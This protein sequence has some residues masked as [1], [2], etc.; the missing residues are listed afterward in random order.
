MTSPPPCPTGRQDPEAGGG[1]LVVISGPSGVGKTTICNALLTQHLFQ[2]VVTATSRPPR[3]GERD[4][5]DY[6]FLT[7]GAFEEGLRLGKF[8]EHARVHGN[9]YG[10]PRREVE[11]G[12]KA[13]KQVLLNIDVQGARQ[14]REAARGPSPLPLVLIFIAPPTWEE[15]ERRLGS[16]GTESPEAAHRRLETARREMDERSSYDHL[17]VNDEVPLAVQRILVALGLTK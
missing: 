14:I 12:L 16:R 7:E 4:G 3:P 8:L 2:R 1:R 5:V 9:L 15:L 13:G 17:V 6:H 11:E 10:T